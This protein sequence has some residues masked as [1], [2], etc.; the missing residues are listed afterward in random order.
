MLTDPISP[1]D[2]DREGSTIWRIE[3]TDN[4]DSSIVSEKFSNVRLT[5]ANV[6]ITTGNPSSCDYEVF[7]M[8][9]PEGSAAIQAKAMSYDA[10]NELIYVLGLTQYRATDSWGTNY[11]GAVWTAYYAAFNLV[12]EL[13]FFLNFHQAGFSGFFNR[14]DILVSPNAHNYLFLTSSNTPLTIAKYT[15]GDPVQ[16]WLKQLITSATNNNYFESLRQSVS[17][18]PSNPGQF[19]LTIQYYG[20]A[21]GK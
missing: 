10:T 9:H 1:S 7:P 21:T 17:E 4:T 6:T 13:Q 3:Y 16:V 5:N 15:Q 8:L 11:G 2:I 12:G 14:I 19:A 18:D 20:T